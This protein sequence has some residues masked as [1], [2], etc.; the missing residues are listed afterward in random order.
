MSRIIT[1]VKDNK[2][3]E[4]TYRTAV[5]RYNRAIKEGFYFEAL[6]IDYALIEDRLKSFIY[7]IGLMKTRNSYRIDCDRAKRSFKPIIEEYKSQNENASFTCSTISGKMKII[8]SSLIWAEQETYDYNDKYLRAIRQQYDKYLDADGLLTV[9]EEV[10]TWCDYRNEI[11]HALLNKN[12]ESVNENL[13]AQALI[14]IELARY[15]DDQV[16]NVKKGNRIR[17]SIGLPDK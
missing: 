15:I 12:V 8:R 9:L 3:K 2:D 1:P 7:H 11:I 13:E 6:L 4:I 10:R 16:K 5:S 14:G 17:R